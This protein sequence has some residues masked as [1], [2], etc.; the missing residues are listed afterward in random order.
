MEYNMIFFFLI[1]WL[2]Y[3]EYGLCVLLNWWMYGVGVDY[4]FFKYSKWFYKWYVRG[5]WI[6]LFW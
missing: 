5:E 2:I 3:V 6:N 1:K 4:G